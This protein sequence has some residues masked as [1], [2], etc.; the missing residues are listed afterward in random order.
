M[1]WLPETN[2]LF[3]RATISE[4]LIQ[5]EI[6]HLLMINHLNLVLTEQNLG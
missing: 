4:I 1:S 6:C 5:L 3:L 2:L